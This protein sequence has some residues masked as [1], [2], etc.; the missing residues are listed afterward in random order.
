ME[1]QIAEALEE[2]NREVLKSLKEE[3]LE[4]NTNYGRLP[5]EMQDYVSYIAGKIE[6]LNES[7]IDKEDEVYKK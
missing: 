2:K 5:D 4:G 1:R 3:L 7:S 6:I